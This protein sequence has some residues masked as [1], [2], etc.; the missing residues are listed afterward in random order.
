MEK[1]VERC[2]SRLNNGTEIET[3]ALVYGADKNNVLKEAWMYENGFS[4]TDGFA[5]GWR[6]CFDTI[7]S[8]MKKVEEF[9]NKV[10]K[11]IKISDALILRIPY[12]K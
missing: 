9:D 6:S 5:E 8:Y 11:D 3:Y 7:M 10:I 4:Y 12:K 1:K 2:V